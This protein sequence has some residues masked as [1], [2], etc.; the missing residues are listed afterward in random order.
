[1]EERGAA[2]P[3]RVQVGSSV[4]VDVADTEGARG[5]GDD[6]IGPSVPGQTFEEA[7]GLYGYPRRSTTPRT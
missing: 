6:E 2:G 3:R 1:M 4:P 7:P 5:V